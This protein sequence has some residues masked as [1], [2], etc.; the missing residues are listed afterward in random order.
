MQYFKL[1]I[2]RI[3]KSKFTWISLILILSIC[4]YFLRINYI[5]NN[6]DSH[7]LSQAKSN[8]IIQQ[9]N[10]KYFGK[11]LKDSKLGTQEKKQMTGDLKEAKST[12]KE[13]Q[14]LIGALKN[15]DWKTAYPIMI[16]QEKRNL[17]SA[18]KDNL[19][20]A[21]LAMS[22][23][24]LRQLE[25]LA[26]LQIPKEN[27]ASIKG[28]FFVL[29]MMETTIPPLVV[30]AVIFILVKIYS[31]GFFER[32]RLGNL[33]PQK[34][35]TL[36]EFYTGTTIG[37]GY[38]LLIFFLIFLLPSIFFGTGNFNYPITAMN[39]QAK[40]YIFIPMFRLFLPTL[41]LE[42][43]SF[44]FIAAVVL[45]IIQLFKRRLVALLLSVFLLVGGMVLP[46][47][48]IGVRSFA[49]Y[50][51]MSYFFALQPV[52]GM[53][54][55]SNAYTF[56]D[57]NQLVTYPQVNFRNGVIVLVIGTIVI[58]LLN[59]LIAKSTQKGRKIK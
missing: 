3:L 8:L 6:V 24:D 32:M 7:D 59:C 2:K 57:E 53:F 11:A 58:L 19:D 20:N 18:K 45:L 48:V 51:P 30:L 29:Q 42:L 13:L 35:L 41:F 31:A 27:Y 44:A 55:I 25:I 14:T 40:E 52:E 50:L 4:A 49:Q 23:R 5:V 46:Q 17:A 34:K 16:R 12:S 33:L 37:F 47:F 21:L 9:H 22:K 10:I 28:G 43:L 1:Q 26:K 15:N 54:G 39:P 56:A 38:F 36:T